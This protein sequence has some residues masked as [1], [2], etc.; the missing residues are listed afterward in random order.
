[1][2]LSRLRLLYIKQIIE[3]ETDEV[4]GLT[5]SGIKAKLIE[6][7]GFTA[8]DK[9]L[10]ADMRALQEYYESCKMIFH[11][12][13]GKDHTYR[14][15][16]VNKELTYQERLYL[17]DAVQT[18]KFLSD[19]QAKMLLA[20]IVGGHGE[21]FQSKVRLANHARMKN[22]KIWPSV[23]TIQKAIEQDVQLRFR[24]YSF[25]GASKKKVYRNNG[26]DLIANPFS[27]VYYNGMYYMLAMVTREKKVTA[28]QIDKMEMVEMR[29]VPRKGI[30][31]YERMKSEEYTKS[32]FGMDMGDEYGKIIDATLIFKNH[33]ADKVLE[34]FGHDAFL[35]KE[36]DNHFRVTVPVVE[37]QQ[38]Y[39]W[40]FSLGDGCE[41][42]K[43]TGLKLRFVD[44][45][46]R[47]LQNC[48]RESGRALRV[49]LSPEEAMLCNHYRFY[50]R[51]KP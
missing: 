45:L 49:L 8:D 42:K 22:E 7:K 25:Y 33:L 27:T 46:A 1:M 16:P 14:L 44:Y 15:V 21:R 3:E 20:K 11:I 9:T 32:V 35:V 28:F 18:T 30:E 6:R 23:L 17:S 19:N 47:V 50:R 4:H 37:S 26:K 48:G 39:T 2:S 10:Q 12:P 5:L 29:T 51:L 36:D 31:I 13:S 38:F 40:L 43:P 41:I 34:Q 24:Y